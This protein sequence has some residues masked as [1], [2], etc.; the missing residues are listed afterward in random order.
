M[1]YALA[2]FVYTAG[3]KI[4]DALVVTGVWYAAW[5]LRFSSSLFPI[6]KG[7]PPFKEYSSVSFWLVLVF[8]VVFHLVGAYRSDR[9]RFGFKA[10][11][12]VCEGSLLSI[13]VFIA[14]CYFLRELNFSRVFLS[15][16]PFLLIPALVLERALL[17]FVWKIA[18]RKW[19]LPIRTLVLGSGD[20][21]NFYLQKINERSPYPIHWLGR[22]GSF[23]AEGTLNALPYLGEENTLGDFIREKPVDRI[24]VSYPANDA[25]RYENVLQLLSNEMVEVKVLPDFGRFST[26]AYSA[27]EE[28]SVPLLL[29][30]QAPVGAT[31]RALKRCLDIVG[32]LAF[33]ILFAPFYFVIAVLIK[34][35]SKG[36]IIYKQERMG[37][38]GRRFWLYKF[39]SMKTDA[40]TTTGAVWAREGDDRTTSLGKWLR[41]TS[42]DETPQ[43]L[44]VLRG[45]M[46]LVGPRPERPIFVDQFRKE[47]PKYMLRH[48]MKSGITGWAQVNGWRGNTSLEQRI[49]HDLFYIIHWS[50]LL[51]IKILCLTLW[52]GFVHKNA[53]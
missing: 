29:F 6:D 2:L 15:L 13:L 40:E 51:D 24:V 14:I 4:A 5:H 49:K 31:D 11:K 3:L 22:L 1:D 38:D 9:V 20:L 23:E 17:E 26:F 8:L 27:Q 33:M 34:L 39:R 48:K 18:Q 37:A 19:L 50:I 21:L 30:N 46:S 16:L 36:P 42:L 41:K 35:N 43:F 47:I 7:L 32:S 53:Y 28:C 52:K 10:V 45:E 12:K 25:A 44:N